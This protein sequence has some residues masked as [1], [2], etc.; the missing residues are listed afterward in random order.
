MRVYAIQMTVRV[1]CFVGAI[2]IPSWPVRI[3][4]IVGA[5]VLPYTAV[6]FA[7]ASGQRRSADSVGM[8]YPNLPGA[9][10]EPERPAIAPGVV[11]EQ[12]PDDGAQDSRDDAPDRGDDQE[13][14]ARH[15]GDAA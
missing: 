10:D 3:V 13:P 6:I 15:H 14:H 12:Q 4:L 5:V 1:L 9:A 8:E 11:L 2:L 7:N